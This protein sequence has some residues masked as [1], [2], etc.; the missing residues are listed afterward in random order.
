MALALFSAGASLSGIHSQ[1]R[2]AQS[3]ARLAKDS[4]VR[5]SVSASVN[6]GSV[7][8]DRVQVA[9]SAAFHAQLKGLN[10][11]ADTA[12]KASSLLQAADAGLVKIGAKLD[13]IIALTKSLTATY[14][15]N[16]ISKLEGAQL[17]AEFDK[18]KAEIDTIAGDTEFQGTKLLDGGSGAGGEFEAA[19]HIGTGTDSEDDIT[20]SIA[21]ADVA[22][23]SSGLNTGNLQSQAAATTAYA[24]AQEAQKVLNKIRGGI[25]G[26]LER[27]G[28]VQKNAAA[29]G[30]HVES[31]RADLADPTI[32]IDFS[33]ITAEKITDDAGVHL[34]QGSVQQLQ[35]LLS[36]IDTSTQPAASDQTGKTEITSGVERDAAVASAL[37]RPA[38]S[39]G[40]SKSSGSSSSSGDSGSAEA[41]DT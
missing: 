25:S 40:T 26:D 4:R 19:F 8:S 23:L 21:K 14:L 9:A 18:L 37:T 35:N 24:D 7:A 1:A 34:V 10:T 15:P 17:D 11:V 22:S 2:E 27:F 28:A 38:A 30:V 31:A 5:S 13:E 41:S 33:R 39:S 29:F 36:R 12:S 16:E 3:I 32:A 6:G 20:V